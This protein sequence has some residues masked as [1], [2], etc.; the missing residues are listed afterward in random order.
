MCP[1]QWR[2]LPENPGR[3]VSHSTNY[4]LEGLGVIYEGN[5]LLGYSLFNF[6]QRCSP[7]LG[8]ATRGPGIGVT[9]ENV[10]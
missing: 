6:C 9:F 3:R 5:K 7:L 4:E 10:K 2:R 1:H 8:E